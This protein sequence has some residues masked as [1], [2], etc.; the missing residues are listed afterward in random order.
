MQAPR[1]KRATN[2]YCEYHET[3]DHNNEDFLSLKYFIEDQIKKGNMNQYLRRRTRGTNAGNKN[4]VN[5]V[6]GGQHSPL[7]NEEDED[8]FLVQPSEYEVITFSSRDFES[9]SPTH[10]EALVVSVDIMENEVKQ[11][12]IDNGY[13][14][15]ILFKHVMD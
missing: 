3:H 7:R 2:K 1:D 10:N 4:M 8:V 12:L 13:T 14:V 9:L 11:F 6:I 5:V 15:N